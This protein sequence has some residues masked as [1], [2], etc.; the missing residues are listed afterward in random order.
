MD[1]LVKQ[2]KYKDPEEAL[3]VARIAEQTEQYTDMVDIMRP[4]IE[5]K[6]PNTDLTQE[7][8]ALLSVAYKNSVGLKRIA[9]RAAKKAL[10]TQ[11]FS[12][13]HAHIEEYVK[14]L[15]EE[16][17]DICKE[18]LGLITKTLYPQAKKLK[19]TEA[20]VYYLKMKGDYYRYVAEVSSGERH[21]KGIDRCLKEYNDGIGLAENLQPG[22]PT[23]LSL[24]LNFSIFCFESL[25]E[26]QQALDMAN[27]AIEEAEEHLETV[28]KSKQ[29]ESTT[30][31][32]FLKENVKSWQQKLNDA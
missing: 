28:E 6:D 9:W 10:K 27:Q 17:V 32:T 21:K 23:R 14:V 20:M 7:E 18:L 25:G 13:Y 3:W 31:M 2:M 30:I 8:R 15:E 11:K 4:Y 16:L 22:D 24:Q 19:N 26:E 12:A 1:N 29:F 5:N